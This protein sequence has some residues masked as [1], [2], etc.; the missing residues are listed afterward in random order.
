[1]PIP[2]DDFFGKMIITYGF[3]PN[4]AI[5][6]K[7]LESVDIF[8]YCNYNDIDKLFENKYIEVVN[9]EIESSQL[10]IDEYLELCVF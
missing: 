1:M 9:G 4:G 7:E 3:T 2:Q 6:K 8:D 10:Q 5:N